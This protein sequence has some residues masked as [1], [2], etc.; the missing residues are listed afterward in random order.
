MAKITTLLIKVRLDE[1]SGGIPPA[2][3]DRI[4]DSA[5][6]VAAEAVASYGYTVVESN[7]T[8]ALDTDG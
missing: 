5:V 3:T 6:V 2:L 1:H 7:R 8:K 4:L